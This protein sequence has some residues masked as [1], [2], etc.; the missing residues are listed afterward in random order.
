MACSRAADDPPSSNQRQHSPSKSPRQ[1]PGVDAASTGACSC[2]CWGRRL[3]TAAS[4]I[5]VEGGCISTPTTCTS[6]ISA[7]ASLASEANIVISLAAWL[8]VLFCVSKRAATAWK[9]APDQCLSPKPHHNPSGCPAIRQT[10]VWDVVLTNNANTLY[11]QAH[12]QC[13]EQFQKHSAIMHC[14][15]EREE[16]TLRRNGAPG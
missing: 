2:R 10:Q 6:R 16:C 12:V 3:M 9:L 11:L 13:G 5:E 14:T 4:L 15:W 8:D 7:Q 1:N